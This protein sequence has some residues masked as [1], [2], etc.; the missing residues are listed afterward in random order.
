MKLYTDLFFAVSMKVIH[1]ITSESLTNKVVYQILSSI[2][3]YNQYLKNIVHG[4]EII[5]YV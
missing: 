1:Q 2:I 3:H 4:K 5:C